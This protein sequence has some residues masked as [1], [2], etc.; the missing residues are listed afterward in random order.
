MSGTQPAEGPSPRASL[1]QVDDQTADYAEFAAWR[2][3]LMR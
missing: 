1:E 2:N 3:V